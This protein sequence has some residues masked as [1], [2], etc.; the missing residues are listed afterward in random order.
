MD[1][2]STIMS[3]KGKADT[4]EVSGKKEECDYGRNKSGKLWKRKDV[5]IFMGWCEPKDRTQT[6]KHL[7]KAVR[8]QSSLIRKY[9]NT[10]R[11][12]AICQAMSKSSQCALTCLFLAIILKRWGSLSLSPFYRCGN[13]VTEWLSNWP[14]VTQQLEKGLLSHSPT[15]KWTP[16]NVYWGTV[17]SSI[18]PPVSCKFISSSAQIYKVGCGHDSPLEPE[19]R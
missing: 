10:I 8:M 3:G 17:L 2:I 13:Q 9:S 1:M 12:P 16:L 19:K 5:M 15:D 6:M 18:Y 11:A 4:V 14:K 7:Q